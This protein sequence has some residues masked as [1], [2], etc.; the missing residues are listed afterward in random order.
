[1][2]AVKSEFKEHTLVVCLKSGHRLLSLPCKLFYI[3]FF[4]FF[5]TAV[6]NVSMFFFFEVVPATR[7]GMAHL[8]LLHLPQNTLLS[9]L[10]VEIGHGDAFN[11]NQ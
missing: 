6:V 7:A 8:I 4:F 3:L 9:N 2:L 1:M 5:F 11:T 10:S